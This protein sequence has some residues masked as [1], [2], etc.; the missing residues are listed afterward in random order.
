[1]AGIA[2]L[3]KMLPLNF[4]LLGSFLFVRIVSEN[5]GAVEIND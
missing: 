1:M 4:T 5:T 3:P 2:P